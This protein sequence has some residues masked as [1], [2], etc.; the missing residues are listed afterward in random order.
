MQSSRWF[1]TVL[2][3]IG[4]SQKIPSHCQ[5][6]V[7]QTQ[8]FVLFG[9][10]CA[11]PY[12]SRLLFTQ[13]QTCFG[14]SRHSQMPCLE[15]ANARSARRPL[16]LSVPSNF[17]TSVSSQRGKSSDND[18]GVS[19]RRT[20]NSLSCATHVSAVASFSP[21]LPCALVPI[22]C[23]KGGYTRTRDGWKGCTVDRY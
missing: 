4:V 12:Q 5:W 7:A 2:H 22:F 15:N 6:L 17:T 3:W 13:M 20:K 14:K 1:R 18:Q 11:M 19:D 16:P 21:C 8:M 10:S 9:R 23:V